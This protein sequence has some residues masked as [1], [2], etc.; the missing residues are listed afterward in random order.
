MAAAN[1]AIVFVGGGCGGAARPILFRPRGTLP[2]GARCSPRRRFPVDDVEQRKIVPTGIACSAPVAVVARAEVGIRDREG[3]LSALLAV[4]LDDCAATGADGGALDE[5]KRWRCGWVPSG[6]FLGGFQFREFLIEFGGGHSVLRGGGVSGA[7][8]FVDHARN[9]GD[10]SESVK[11]LLTEW[12]RLSE[13]VVTLGDSVLHIMPFTGTRRLTLATRCAARCA[14]R[15]E[16]RSASDRIA[17]RLG[18]RSPERATGAVLGRSIQRLPGS[19]PG[20]AR[21]ALYRLPWMKRA[22]A[23]RPASV[24]AV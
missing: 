17:T 16:R 22:T 10:E 1:W 6:Q 13:S 11:Q 14:R 24:A 5:A 4:R 15:A 19:D 12:A 21:L 3:F 18:R 8:A 9:I 7:V 23:P 20:S 2:I